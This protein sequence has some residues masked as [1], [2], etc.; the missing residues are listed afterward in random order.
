VCGNGTTDPGEQC[1]DGNEEN[2]DACTNDCLL[3]VCGDGFVRAGVE[4]CDDGNTLNGD[5]CT[6]T[7]TLPAA[8]CGNGCVQ[9]GETCD[10]GNTLNGDS[11]PSNCVIGACTPTS[12]QVRVRIRYNRPN[13]TATGALVVLLD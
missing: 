6:S 4:Q 10:D 1:D 11:C 3:P 2:T 7:C 5:C 13:T 9:A 12:T 8:V